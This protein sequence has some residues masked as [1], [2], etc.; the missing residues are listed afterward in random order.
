MSNKDEQLPSLISKPE[1]LRKDAD[2]AETKEWIEA[3]DDVVENQGKDRAEF[4]VNAVINKAQRENI[5]VYGTKS[6]FINTIPVEEEAETDG[7]LE[8]EKKI[9][10]AV[11]WNAAIMVHRANRPEIGVGGHISTYAGAATL[12][13]T[14]FNHFWK[15]KDHKD[16]GDH[17][18]YQGHASPGMYARAYVE[19]RLDDEDLDGFRQEFSKK[20]GM[21]SYPH[22]RLMQNFWEFPT[23]SMGLGPMNAIY[24]AQSDKYLAHR[25]LKDTKEQQVWAFLGDGEMDEPESRGQLQAAANDHLDNLNFIISCNMQRLD[26]PVRGNGKIMQ[27]LEAFFNGAGWNVIKLVWGSEWDELLKKDKSGKL[28]QLMN[29][30]P[31]GDFQTYS[32]EDGA[33]IREHFFNRYPETAELVKDMSDDEIWNMHRGGHDPKKVYAAFKAASE[34]KD[35]PTVILVNNIKGYGMGPTFEG[36]NA[37]HQMKKMTLEDMKALRDHLD[38]PVTDGQLEADDHWDPPFYR[39]A[40]DSPE[41]KYM[42]EKRKKLGGYLPERRVQKDTLALP[43][44]KNYAFANKGSGKQQ[45]A[46]TM[47]FVR[48]LKD[49]MRDK[50]FGKHVVPII[51]DEARTFGMDSFFP[52]A[53]IYNPNGQTYMSVDRKIMLAY[54]EAP[55]GQILH[56]GINEGGSLSAFTAAGSAYATHGVPLVPVYIFYSMFGF[57]RTADSIWAA[58][59]QMARGFMIGATAGR[60]TLAGEGL[61]HMDGHSLVLAETNPAVVAYDPAYGY[62]IALI[63]K[64]GLE[65]M[66]GPDSDDRN[67]IYYMT[68]YNEP[69]HQPK[70]PED[71]DEEGVLRGMYLAKESDASGPK[72]QLLASGVGVPWILEAQE[73]LEE[74]W[75][76]SADVWSVTSWSELRRE[77]LRQEEAKLNGEDYEIPYVT[78]KLKETEGPVVATSDWNKQVPDMIRQFV[79]RDY[80]VL[81]AD[82]FGVSDT[83]AAARRHFRIDSH[84]VVV[85][86]LLSLEEDGS[87]EKGTAAKA[88]KK[89]ELGNDNA[90]TSGAVGGDA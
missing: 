66:Y 62:E 6:D 21:P 65:R 77:G 26:G 81:G 18:F 71:L 50:E 82:D 4:V 35:G 75:G 86:T 61:Q 43:A 28:I 38:I 85:R 11:R 14:G 55:D 13:E 47:A 25:G 29:E 8:I 37:T 87:I 64:D 78:K 40:E 84:S 42:H 10:N 39:P 20:K 74:D 48:L 17:I 33:F 73:L 24:Q 5:P 54:K 88:F 9:E 23:V 90:G 45:A 22:P 51:P 3:L 19:G 32:T 53:K 80:A 70:K 57:Q 12:Y 67:L 46:T 58:A 7:D 2:P 79:P 49:L 69:I 60:T 63:V 59:D 56:V 83:R 15:G 27:E 1:A 68:V 16:G 30:T 76:V 44:D 36:R 31:D 89:Y 41:M 72:A 52:T 34:H